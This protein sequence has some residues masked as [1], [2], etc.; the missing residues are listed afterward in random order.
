MKKV[1]IIFII[2][3]CLLISSCNKKTTVVNN[4]INQTVDIEDTVKIETLEDAICNTVLNVEQSVV[5]IKAYN[6]NTLLKT[7]SFGSGVII[8]KND[9]KYYIVTNRHV[10]L[11]QGKV[12]NNIKIYLGNLDLYI[13]GKVLT[14]DEKVDLPFLLLLTQDQL[15]HHMLKLY[16]QYINLN[17]LNI[18]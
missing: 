16:H 4:V 11:K 17:Y 12:Y 1:F 3:I 15:F 2:V 9:N 14:Y 6:D 8:S 10:I 18:F 7:E 5:G 13:D